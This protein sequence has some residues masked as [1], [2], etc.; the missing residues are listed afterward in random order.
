MVD[1]KIIEHLKDR[2]SYWIEVRTY[3]KQKRKEPLWV[4]EPENVLSDKMIK[5]LEKYEN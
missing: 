4:A 5:S 1:M 2:F 3:G